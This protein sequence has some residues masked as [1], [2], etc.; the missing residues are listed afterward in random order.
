[1]TEAKLRTRASVR[2]EKS[3]NY[4]S[5]ASNESARDLV[6]AILGKGWELKVGILEVNFTIGLSYP[7]MALHHAA[8][9]LETS[10]STSNKVFIDPPGLL[11]NTEKRLGAFDL[12]VVRVLGKCTPDQGTAASLA[13]LK[14]GRAHV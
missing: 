8:N 12:L 3:A 13:D 14:I 6:S 7:L 10:F 2:G 11:S 4:L 5:R 9:A 1:M